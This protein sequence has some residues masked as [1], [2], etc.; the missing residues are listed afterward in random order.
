M[1]KIRNEIQ[2]AWNAFQSR[3]EGMDYDFRHGPFQTFRPER[4][5]IRLS[6]ERTIITPILNRMAIDVAAI[7]LRHVRVDNNENYLEELNSGLT[8]CL[9]FEANIDQTSQAFKMDIAYTLFD[10]GVVAIVPVDTNL[11]PNLTGGYDIKTMRAGTVTAWYPRHVKVNL[12][13][14]ELGRREEIMVPKSYCAI[15]ENPLYSVMNEPN[16]TLKRLIHKLNLLDQVDDELSS[17][18]LNMIIKLPYVVKSEAKR[19]QAE[20][21]RTDLELQLAESKYGIGY[22]DGTE[23]VTQLNG[24]VENTLPKQVDDLTNLLYAQLGLTRSVI[25]GTANEQEMLNYYTRTIK[26][27]VKALAEGMTRTFLTKTARAQNQRVLFVRDPFELVPVQ[28][29]ADIVDKFSRNEVLSSNEVRGVI[30]FRPSDDPKA[31][32]LRNSNMPHPEDIP[33]EQP[34]PPAEPIDLN[35]PLPET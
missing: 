18:K 14:E 2:H 19:K 1:S 6:S 10:D 28:N 23:D 3:D 34:P 25:E 33:Q 26:P 31:D 21:R 11:N 16:S 4:H 22:I 15:V 5:V 32:E 8:D 13:N 35:Q 7:D 17:G 9:K 12:Y 24:S 29:L 20:Q 30:G 27:I